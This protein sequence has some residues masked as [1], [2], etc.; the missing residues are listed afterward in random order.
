GEAQPVYE[1]LGEDVRTPRAKHERGERDRDRSPPEL[2]LQDVRLQ[3]VRNPTHRRSRL[4]RPGRSQV[5]RRSQA[6]ATTQKVM[7][8]VKKTLIA[9]DESPA[10]TYGASDRAR[11]E[12]NTSRRIHRFVPSNTR[13]SSRGSAG[14]AGTRSNAATRRISSPI[15]VLDPFM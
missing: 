8:G 11:S 9:T 14:S 2:S 5:Q 3:V 12:P 7:N 13:V 15:L 6:K 4:A 10:P 1:P